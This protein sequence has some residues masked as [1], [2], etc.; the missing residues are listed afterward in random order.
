[1]N[2]VLFPAEMLQATSICADCFWKAG[3][4]TKKEIEINRTETQRTYFREQILQ[5]RRPLFFRG[6]VGVGKGEQ[7]KMNAQSH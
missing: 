3:K 1:M 4:M 7:G 2:V 5:P 6:Q